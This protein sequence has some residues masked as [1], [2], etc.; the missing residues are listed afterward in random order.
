MYIHKYVYMCMYVSVQLLNRVWFFV[1][2]KTIA[3]PPP[4]C[5]GILQARILEWVAIFSSGD[6]PDPEIKLVSLTSPALAGGFFTP[7][8]SGSYIY[9]YIYIYII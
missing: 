7:V 4:P 9:I 1:T 2:P 5:H 3:H 6:L 8:P